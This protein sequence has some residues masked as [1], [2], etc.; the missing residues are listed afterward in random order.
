[1]SRQSGWAYRGPMALTLRARAK[2]RSGE[3]LV[4]MTLDLPESQHIR[5]K[6]AAI[7]RRV[8]VRRLVMELLEKEGIRAA[9]R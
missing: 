8:T 4:R 9:A 3:E 5:L 2:E 7:K 1:M 6:I